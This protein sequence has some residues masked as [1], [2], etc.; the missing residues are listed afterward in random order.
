MATPDHDHR[1]AIELARAHGF[2]GVDIRCSDFK[3]EV[4][5]DTSQSEL[6]RIADDFKRAGVTIP[7]V[8]CYNKVENEA[9]DCWERLAAEL[10][11]LLAT[12]EALGGGAVRVFGGYAKGEQ[13]IGDFIAGWAAVIRDVLDR[14][15]APVNIILQNHNKSLNAR[16]AIRLAES[17]DHPRFGLAFSPDHCLIQKECDVAE[18]IRAAR[19]WTKELYLSDT[20]VKDGKCV[21]CL[22]GEGD[23][24]LAEAVRCFEESDFDGYYC[25]KW[26]KIWTRNLPEADVALPAFASFMAGI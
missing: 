9:P 22:P 13:T 26:E 5:P 1:G 8:L 24:P 25:F 21:S 15:D 19:R 2:Q 20:A 17:V 14:N 11:S 4:T 7:G 18:I 16:E 23:V 3:G 6:K 10:E 12:V